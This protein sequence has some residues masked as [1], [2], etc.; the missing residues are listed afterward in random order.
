MMTLFEQSVALPHEHCLDVDYA[1]VLKQVENHIEAGTAE[2]DVVLFTG[3]CRYW[4]H[5]MHT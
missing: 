2:G 1:A 3:F 5:G 4:P